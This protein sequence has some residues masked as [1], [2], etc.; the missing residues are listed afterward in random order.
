MQEILLSQKYSET[1]KKTSYNCNSI[2][3]NF[4]NVRSLLEVS[5]IV[6]LQELMLE[7]RDLDVLYDLH[8][9][10]KYVAEVRDREMEGICE[11]RPSR[12]VAVYWRDTFSS[13]ISP[14][15]VSD[16]LIGIVLN[17]GSSKLLILN[18]YLPCDTQNVFAVNEYKQSLANVEI[19]IREQNVNEVLL[20]GILM[21]ILIKEG[22]GGFLKILQIHYNF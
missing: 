1:M 11:G 7:K 16:S 2:R 5:D 9:D 22:F 6:L 4:E 18:V 8:N 19:V 20:W 15:Y 10:F 3:N 13:S 17:S 14:V 21:L 12:G